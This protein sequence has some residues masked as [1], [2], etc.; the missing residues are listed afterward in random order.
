[1]VVSRKSLCRVPQA[2]FPQGCGLYVSGSSGNFYQC[3]E[4]PRSKSRSFLF[5][6]PVSPR[7]VKLSFYHE[8]R[9]LMNFRC[10][11]DSTRKA[12]IWYSAPESKVLTSFIHTAFRPKPRLRNARSARLSGSGPRSAASSQDTNTLTPASYTAASRARPVFGDSLG[13]FGCL[14]ASSSQTSAAR[15]GQGTAHFSARAPR[16]DL[17]G[18][19]LSRGGRP[20]LDKKEVGEVP[21]TLATALGAARENPLSERVL[22]S[23][24]VERFVRHFLSFRSGMLLKSSKACLT[25]THYR[26]SYVGNQGQKSDFLNSTR[27]PVYEE[28]H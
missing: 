19:D 21:S 22:D 15:L 25:D 18:L 12:G 13:L 10:L 16:N 7:H 8:T 26:L 23:N 9:S 1:M 17:N 6:P 27:S 28:V 4:Q 24:A 20:S 3:A 11:N 2:Q 14:R 5:R